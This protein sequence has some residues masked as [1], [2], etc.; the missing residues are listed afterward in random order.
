[1]TLLLTTANGLSE[2]SKVGN[3]IPRHYIVVSIPVTHPD[4]PA[5]NGMVRGQYESVEMIREIPLA[6]SSVASASMSDLLKQE[7]KRSRERGGTIGFAESRGPD[8]KGE[9][10]DR[11][12][13]ADGNDAETNPVE[14]IMVTRSDPGGG[15]PRF[16]VERGTPSSIVQ[17]AGKFLDWACKKDDLPEHEQHHQ[18]VRVSPRMSVDEERFS[19]SGTNGIMAGVGTSIADR[20]DP[21]TFR[22]PSQQHIQGGDG[23]SSMLES[24]SNT[25]GP[26]IPNALTPLQR[27]SSRSSSTSTSSLE[28]FASAEQFN[29]A[30]E[31]LAVNGS[32][33]SLSEVS[34]PPTQTDSPASREL[35]KIEQKRQRLR[36]KLDQSR[37]TQSQGEQ[38]AS[39]KSLK[40]L[41]RA[42]EKH[43]KERKKQED[44]FAKEVEKLEARRERETKKLLA[45]QQKE[46]D[47]SSLQKVTGER[48]DWKQRAE[49]AEQENKLLHD[50]ISIL[51]RENT[52]LVAR[53]GKSDVGKEI[54]KKVREEDGARRR[55]GSVRSRGS[56]G[57]QGK[58]TEAEGGAQT[59]IDS[60]P[61]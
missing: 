39:L 57:S 32:T 47:K 59:I 45:K 8:A 15:I 52:M 44:K 16:M 2:A 3:T 23:Q 19:I 5:R 46:A 14:W 55:S 50:Q 35:Q 12:D 53:L 1:M 33:A 48:N 28:S 4:A 40:E 27:S 38:D 56:G 37:Q 31:G 25:L 11:V 18:L 21:A 9:K 17:D 22:R 20:P 41:E 58:K 51:Q 10:I 13:D 6:S 54:L 7:R 61:N 30:S 26:Y 42:A 24:L 34:A 36:D 43:N 49:L 60:R 29:T